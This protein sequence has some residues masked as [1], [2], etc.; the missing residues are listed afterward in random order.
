MIAAIA[1]ER[2][3]VPLM[4]VAQVSLSRF[5]NSA[6]VTPFF[7]MFGSAPALPLRVAAG[8]LVMTTVAS[9]LTSTLLV[10]DLRTGYL[11]G[12]AKKSIV[13]IPS[14]HN[15]SRGSVWTQKV[16][17]SVT[18]AEYSE[19]VDVPG[20]MDDT[21]LSIRAFLPI[22]GSNRP[23]KA[24]S[25]QGHPQHSQRTSPSLE[26]KK[27]YNIRTKLAAYPNQPHETSSQVSG[28]LLWDLGSLETLKP[29]PIYV[30]SGDLDMYDASRAR[31]QL[32][33]FTNSTASR[34]R[35]RSVLT[36]STPALDSTLK[37]MRQDYHEIPSEQPVLCPDCMSNIS[38]EL[39][40]LFFE[41]INETN[42]PALALQAIKTALASSIWQD[43]LPTDTKEA[44]ATLVSAVEVLYPQSKREFWA[45]IAT[46]GVHSPLFLVLLNHFLRTHSS[47]LDNVWHTVAQVSESEACVH[48]LEDANLVSDRA[49]GA[50]AKGVQVFDAEAVRQ[51]SVRMT[52]R[53]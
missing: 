25:F 39:N 3:G 26:S 30:W 4:D 34:A 44:N 10:N 7:W 47:F 5:S 31:H 16:S 8:F 17:T 49:V 46:I 11:K 53:R 27:Y 36:I 32:G 43:S 45:I 35:D 22:P 33:A 50:K 18:F 24:L 14:V 13:K 40:A 37:T 28:Y 42:S 38:P 12:F 9:Q 15:P 41:T 6:P 20:D 29:E 23:R 52:D 48:I 21:G 19:E 51:R 2:Q 1:I